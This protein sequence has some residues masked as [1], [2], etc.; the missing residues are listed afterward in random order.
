M[1]IIKFENIEN[2]IMNKLLAGDDPILDLLRKQY[3]K[4]QIYERDYTEIGFFTYFIIPD[5]I[6]RLH[7]LKDFEL[8]DIN[9]DINGTS[10]NI[11]LYIR[12]GAISVLNV[13]TDG[14]S[15]WPK[16]IYSYNL[17]YNQKTFKN[18]PNKRDM[19]ALKE[20]LEKQKISIN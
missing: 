10:V 11:T 2:I 20:H 8:D 5:N 7:D 17:S 4:S 3:K 6:A 15:T 1:N 9:G 14:M 12:N 18:T 13:I 16:I 19:E